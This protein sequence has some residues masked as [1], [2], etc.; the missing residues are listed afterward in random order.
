MHTQ[1]AGLGQGGCRCWCK[2]RVFGKWGLAVRQHSTAQHSVG[3]RPG[4][5][6]SRSAA[7]VTAAA[8]RPA[9]DL[10][11]AKCTP[12]AGVKATNVGWVCP[13]FT[14]LYV[15]RFEPLPHARPAP[16]PGPSATHLPT[17]S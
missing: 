11:R 17:V 8:C 5:H 14:D 9:S 2:H 10:V 7:A 3:S 12:P 4:A 16:D 13:G 15:P 6:L 1:G